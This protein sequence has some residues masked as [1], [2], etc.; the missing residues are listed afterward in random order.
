MPDIIRKHPVLAIALLCM[1]VFFGVMMSPP[2]AAQKLKNA[3]VKSLQNAR[4][5]CL[6]CRVYSRQHGGNFPAT[7]DLLFPQYLQDR[8]MLASPLSPGDAVGYTYTPPSVAKVDSP[9]T[10]V[11]E[12]KFA[13]TL[14]GHRVVVYANASAR[15]IMQAAATP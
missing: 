8:G 5:I 1:L 7:F 12:D 9:D 15:I 3:E 14:T 2:S 11:L 13:P 4:N 10:V 6:A